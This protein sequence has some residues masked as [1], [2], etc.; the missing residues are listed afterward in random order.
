MKVSGT[1][2]ISLYL[3]SLLFVSSPLTSFAFRTSSNITPDRFSAASSRSASS[4][5]PRR[6]SSF[7]AQKDNKNVQR[8]ASRLQAWTD[9]LSAI[10]SFYQSAPYAAAALT[11]GAKASAADF[12]AQKRQ[13]SK[14]EIARNVAFLIYGALYQGMGQEFIYNHCYADWFGDSNSPIVVLKKV[15]FDLF[16]QTTFVTLPM[17]Y[18]TK[19]VIFHHSFAEGLRRYKDDVVNKGL[20][21][22]YFKIWGPVQC[23]T[24]GVIPEHLRISF[25]AA[26]SFFWLIIFSTVSSGR[27]RT[28]VL[29]EQPIVAAAKDEVVDIIKGHLVSNE[30]ALA[31]SGWCC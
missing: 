8:T 23:L 30:T 10:D 12:V 6:P 21:M 19:A 3:F 18:L 14:F 2:S 7:T 29:K 25:I 15:C 27:T 5:F 31:T 16:V 11:C 20:L 26:V 28:P 13:M 22:K 17:A 1:S 24:F 4:L 9:A